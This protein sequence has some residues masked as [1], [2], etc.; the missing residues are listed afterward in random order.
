MHRKEMVLFTD[1]P[2]NLASHVQ[3][4][5]ITVAYETYGSLNKN[6]SNAIPYYTC[7]DWGCP[8]CET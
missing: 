6:S 8:C 7:L 4:K 2:L 1:K 5:N 3:L